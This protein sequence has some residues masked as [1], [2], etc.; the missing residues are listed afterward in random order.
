MAKAVTKEVKSIDAP[1]VVK[2]T[3]NEGENVV[4]TFATVEHANILRNRLRTHNVPH[5][6]EGPTEAAE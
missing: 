1:H 5:T 4:A 6:Y 2:H 3:N